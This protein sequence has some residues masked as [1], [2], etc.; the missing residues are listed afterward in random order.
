MGDKV[1]GHGSQARLGHDDVNA[2]VELG[3]HLLGLVGV[4][5]GIFNGSEQLVVDLRILDAELV[6]TVLIE[7]RH[8]STVLDGAL[9]VVDRNIA[10]K[11]PGR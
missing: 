6:A 9:E 1:A 3:L 11:G 10:A 4:E 7:E 8:C 5:V 2:M